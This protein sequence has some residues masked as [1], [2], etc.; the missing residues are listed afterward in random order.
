VTTDGG[1]G[2]SLE[3]NYYPG[4]GRGLG[5]VKDGYISPAE[6]GQMSGGVGAGVCKIK[7]QENVV[8]NVFNECI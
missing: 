7:G 4:G 1:D 8:I 2:I 3:N 5:K 6:L